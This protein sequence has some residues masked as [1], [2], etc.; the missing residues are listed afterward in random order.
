MQVESQI[1]SRANPRFK[2]LKALLATGGQR[3]SHTL[4][5]G[6]KL[7]LAWSQAA[8]ACR[9]RLRPE[10]WLRLEG[11]APHPLERRLTGDTL[12]LGETLMRDLAE[13][14]SP[15][16][17]ALLAALGPEPEGPL[18]DRVIVPWGIQDPGNLGAILRSAA[19]FG[20]QEALLGPLCADPF[21]PKALRGSMGA[22]FLMPLRRTG[23][24]VLDAGRWYA[25]DGA[26]GALPLAQAP[27]DP[28]LR[29]LV[30]NEGHGWQGSQL[31]AAVRR[32]AIP[33]QGV[34]SLNAAVAAGIACF[35][36]ARRARP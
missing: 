2:S 21:A 9:D 17:H 15:P 25:L 18:A 4:L 10:I 27:L 34:E 35:E 30:G 8:A 12:V 24:L 31:P 28:P 22:A 13:A 11:A 7:I 32:V 23:E 16:E 26:P 36:A 29:I 20:F 3:R 19:A 1:S 14:G 6:E 5:L 33:T